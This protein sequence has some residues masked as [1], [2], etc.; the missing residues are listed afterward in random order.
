MEK[1]KKKTV[2][3]VFCYIVSDLPIYFLICYIN[4]Q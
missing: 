4:I 3:A 1:K 2:N